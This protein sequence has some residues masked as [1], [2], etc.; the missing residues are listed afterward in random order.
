MKIIVDAM[1]GDN[2]PFEIVKGSLQAMAEL[3]VEITL[4]GRTEAIMESL[5]KLGHSSLPAGLEIVNATEVIDM[6]EEPSMA[7]RRKPDSSLTV[8]LNLLKNGQGDAMVSAGSTGALLSGATLVVKRI[9]GVRRAGLAPLIPTQ[10]GHVLVIDVGANVECTSEHLLQF[11]QLGSAFVRGTLGIENPRVCLLNN[12]T[13]SSKG[14]S[15]QLETYPLLQQLH[16]EGKLNFCG[17]VEAKEVMNGVC[18]VI[19]CDG[20]SG[21]ILLKA[22][23]GTANFIMKNLKQSMTKNVKAK[24][25]AL[26]LKK[27]VYALKDK[28]SSSKVGGTALLGISKPVIKA[29]G[30]SDAEAMFNAIRQAATAVSTD[31]IGMVTR[32][33]QKTEE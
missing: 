27:E 17:N 5:H 25:G 29:H 10:D 2:A 19:V 9:R 26:L 7:Y 31:V 13:E 15:L 18:D 4:T 16:E 22:I 3:G 28:M 23:E 20:Y 32:Q 8:G 14:G 33:L 6:C 24:L 30:S 12:G 21:N 11:A 1:G